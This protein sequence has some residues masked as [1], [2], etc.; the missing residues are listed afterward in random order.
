MRR[1]VRPKDVEP[2][3]FVCRCRR[4]RLARCP[5]LGA[6]C[7][8]NAR[9]LRLVLCQPSSLEGPRSQALGTP[10]ARKGYPEPADLCSSMVNDGDPGSGSSVA[11]SGSRYVL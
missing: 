9:L 8:S 5:L 2:L 4:C 11:N 3:F 7:E 10:F 6:L 1:A